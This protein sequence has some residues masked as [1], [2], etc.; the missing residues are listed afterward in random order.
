MTLAELMAEVGMPRGL[1]RAGQI[2][3]LRTKFAELNN[4]MNKETMTHKRMAIT[5]QLGCVGRLRHLLG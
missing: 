2:A 3:Y 1:D 4:A 5:R